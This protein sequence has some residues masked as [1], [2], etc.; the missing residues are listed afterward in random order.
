MRYL[1]K[2]AIIMLII[3]ITQKTQFYQHLK[4][5]QQTQTKI[6]LTYRIYIQIQITFHYFL[7]T[8]VTKIIQINQ[9]QIQLILQLAL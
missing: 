2:T 3:T 1:Y 8:M 5:Q 6:H 7:Q 9:T 4:H